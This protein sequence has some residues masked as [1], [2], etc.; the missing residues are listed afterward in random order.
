MRI[1]RL[2]IAVR[3]R[4]VLECLDLALVVCGRRPL[5]VAVAAAIGVL[6]MILLNRAVF[7][8]APEDDESVL[9]LAVALALEMP[10]ATAPLTLFL[11]QAVFSERFTATSWRECLRAFAGAIW[12]LLLF[13][14]FFRG[15]SLSCASRPRSSRITGP[16]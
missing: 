14:G 4:G 7:T 3:P 12:P 15:G 8:G 5:G 9:A 11:G 10:W 6:P 13:Q 16:R 1:D 2:Q